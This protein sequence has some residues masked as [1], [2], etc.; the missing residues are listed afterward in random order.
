[1][2]VIA[3]DVEARTPERGERALDPPEELLRPGRDRRIVLVLEIAELDEEIHSLGVHEGDA[4]VHFGGGFPIRT[5]AARLDV[6]VMG[7]GHDA[8]ADGG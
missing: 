4:F 5:G 8:E 6:G 1:M 7:V 2:I 3:Q